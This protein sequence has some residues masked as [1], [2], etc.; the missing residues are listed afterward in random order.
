M[1]VVVDIEDRNVKY[2]LEFDRRIN[3]IVGDS[4]TGKT[5]I[6]ELIESKSNDSSIKVNSNIQCYVINRTT[7]EVVVA[8][9]KD[10]LVIFDDLELI[11]SPLFASL[12]HKYCIRNN[13]Y[14]LLMCRDDSDDLTHVGRL[15]F[16]TNSIFKLKT[17]N[18]VHL[19]FPYY[20]YTK[21]NCSTYDLCIV[22][23]EKSGY[24]FFKSLF[25]NI[26]VESSG[27]KSSIISYTETKV[28]EGYSNILVIF[29]TASFGCHIEEF[30][31]KLS[32]YDCNISIISTY[33]CFEE[34]L[35]RTNIVNHLDEVKSI[36]S[37][38]PDY[39][40]DC[41]SWE[42]YFEDWL[43]KL[44]KDKLYKQ[45]HGRGASLNQCYKCDVFLNGNKFE[46]MLKGTKYEFL[47]SFKNI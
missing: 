17:V 10:A 32:R 35:V 42:N 19:L 38:L 40:N 27:G 5:T 8:G 22:E 25:S 30:Y 6:A 31:R 7:W 24:D 39:A 1:R 46:E 2:H 18:G 45:N 34:L 43:Y 33:E 44:T 16:S 15:S 4:G 23:D 11:S 13:L 14:F 12:V 3:F 28:K 36:L 41:I 26:K 21:N 47:L 29:D 20:E 9:V 37:N